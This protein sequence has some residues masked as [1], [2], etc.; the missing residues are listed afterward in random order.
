VRKVLACFDVDITTR[1]VTAVCGAYPNVKL[2][3]KIAYFADKAL[4]KSL[5]ENI[6]DLVDGITAINTIPMTVV[7]QAGDEVFPG[8]SKAGISGAPI[9]WAGLEMTQY[10][11]KY[12]QAFGYTYKIIGVGGVL[13]ATDFHE[14]QTAGADIVMSVT[15]AMWNSRLAE[16]I[17]PVLPSHVIRF[18]GLQGHETT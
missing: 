11:A 6:G 1:I 5:V 4:L 15:G 14:Y 16:E 10:L 9:K 8:R 17:K 2:L 18:D 7:D 13:T 12:R 3:I